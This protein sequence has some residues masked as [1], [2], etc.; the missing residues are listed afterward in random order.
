M[1]VRLSSFGNI[2]ILDLVSRHTRMRYAAGTGGGEYEGACPFCVDDHN[3]N[4]FRVWPKGGR[5]WCRVCGCK[6]DTIQ[7]VRDMYNL[8]FQQAL[9]YLSIDRALLTERYAPTNAAPPDPLHSPAAAW[10]ARGKTLLVGWQEQFWASVGER[11]RAWLHARG[12][13]DDTMRWAQFGYNATDLYESRDLWGLPPATNRHGKPQRI[14]VPRGIVIPWWVHGELWRLNVR[15]PLTDAEIAQGEAKYIGPAG[16]SNGLYNV[17]GIVAGRPVMLLEG[18]LDACIVQQWAG[19]LITPVATGSTSGS[20]RIPWL[21]RLALA[22]CVLVAYDND[23]PGELASDYWLNAL[24][25]AR[26]WR[27]YWSDVNGMAQDGVDVHDWVGI[28]V[29]TGM[30]RGIEVGNGVQRTPA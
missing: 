4:R 6:G 14:W 11:A 7:F 25:N 17:D 8:T 20:R 22:S 19:H 10:Q 24:P 13:T 23:T 2:N 16:S 15:R 9:D 28:G 21:A 12:I 1:S 3:R 5:Y 30:G 27:P 29:G 18:E 26:R